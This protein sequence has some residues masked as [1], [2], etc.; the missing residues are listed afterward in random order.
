MLSETFQSRCFTNELRTSGFSDHG[1]LF[2]LIL[3]NSEVQMASNNGTEEIWVRSVEQ[4]SPT[5]RHARPFSVV[6]RA[7]VKGREQSNF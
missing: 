1:I 5:E 4:A 7:R 2:L 6:G 3:E